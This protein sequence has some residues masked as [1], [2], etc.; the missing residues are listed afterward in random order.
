MP[1]DAALRTGALIRHNLIQIGREPGPLASRLVLPL[2]FLLL[3]HPLYEQAQHGQRGVAQAVIATLVTF[4]LLAMNLAGSTFLSER[5]WHT[6]E[7]LRTSA[8]RPAELLVG[9]TVPVIAAL[10]LQQALVIGFGAVVLGLAV[11]ALPVLAVVVLAWTLALVGIGAAVGLLARSMTSLAASFD[12]GAMIL[13]S[14]GGALVPLATMPAWVRHVAP[15]SPGY[16]AVSALQAALHDDTGRAL[17]ASAVL[18]AFAC[19]AVLVAAA[20]TSRSWGRSAG[21]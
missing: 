5:I 12:I 14:L 15:A 2:A 21:L 20:R 6:W 11:P 16:W 18:L 1:R 8:A 7:R 9:K 13:S 4:S 19:G 10:I 3:L 17:A